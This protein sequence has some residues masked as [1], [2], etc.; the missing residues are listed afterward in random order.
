MDRNNVEMSIRL[1]LRDCELK[2]FCDSNTLDV[3][4]NMILNIAADENNDLYLTGEQNPM[5]FADAK[6][7][8]E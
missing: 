6:N 5:L 2:S 3:V 7:F 1:N 8:S 4:P